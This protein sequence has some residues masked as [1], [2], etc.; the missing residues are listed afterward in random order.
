MTKDNIYIRR[1]LHIAEKGLG[2][3]AP[4]PMVG[5]VIVCKDKI[6]GEGYHKENGGAHAEVN[7]INSVKDKE[8]LKQSVLYVNLEP[9]S[10][11]G[12]TPP[13]ADLIIKMQIPK[14]VIGNIDPNPIVAGE[15][16]KKLESAGIEVITDVLSNECKELNKRFFTFHNLKRPY[17]ILKWAQSLDGFIGNKKELYKDSKPV[18]ITHENL[19]TL[20][21]KWRAEEQSIMIG[22]NTAL[23]D[24]PKLDVR[25]WTGKNP[26]RVVCDRLLRLPKNLHLFDKTIPT[27]VFTAQNSKNKNAENLEYIQIDF[28][29]NF[30]NQVC[31]VLYKKNIQSLFLEGGTE[32]HQTFINNNMWDEARVFTGNKYLK[33]GV[34]APIFRGSIFSDF[35]FNK[36]KLTIYKNNLT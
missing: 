27:I 29:N 8:T 13:C 1:C 12:K 11:Y 4:N 6:I 36:D 35:F 30:V 15:G 33:E 23:L 16:I 28:E 2:N 34:N 19:R 9:C 10:H 7:A 5:C 31:N 22:T 3:V 18:W 20:V 32:I 21:H 24:N 25:N 26:T 17:I 14:V